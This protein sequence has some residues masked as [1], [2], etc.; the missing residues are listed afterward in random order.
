MPRLKYCLARTFPSLRRIK[1]LRENLGDES[2]SREKGR[3]VER[4]W[5]WG[6]FGR[7]KIPMR[8]NGQRLYFHWEL[9]GQVGLPEMLDPFVDVKVAPTVV[10][11]M[12][13][14]LLVYLRVGLSVIPPAGQVECISIRTNRG[15]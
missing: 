14:P 8:A 1:P 12:P 3:W 9:H 2:H 4:E 6:K 7:E 11:R 10:L 5:F 13:Q 15:M